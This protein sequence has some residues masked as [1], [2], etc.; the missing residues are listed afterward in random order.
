MSPRQPTAQY[1]N[2]RD[3]EA[4]HA[5]YRR[6]DHAHIEAMQ[7][8]MI[9]AIA[10]ETGEEMPPKVRLLLSAIQGAH[11]GGKVVNEE[12]ERNYLALADQLQFTGNEEARRSR[13]RA[14]V[15][16]FEEWQVKTYHLVVITK[17]GEIVGYSDNKDPIY[18]GTKFI[19]LVKPI[20]DQ[21]VMRARETE[22]W[23]GNKEKKIKA[24]PGKALSAQVAWAIKQL[25]R[26]SEYVEPLPADADAVIDTN[27]DAPEPTEEEMIAARLA[28]LSEYVKGRRDRMLKDEQRVN[29]RLC[30]GEM[31]SDAEIDGRLVVLD[32]HHANALKALKD[33]FASAR[34]YL[35]KQ[36]RVRLAHAMNFTHAGDD[37]EDSHAQPSNLLTD[38]DARHGT[39]SG[40][41]G[42]YILRKFSDVPEGEVEE[43]I[44][45]RGGKEKLTPPPDETRI[46]IEESELDMCEAALW[47]ASRGVPVVPLHEVYDGICTC[48]CTRKKCRDGNHGCGSECESKGKHPRTIDGLKSAT[49]DEATIRHWWVKHPT[50]NIGGVT[51]GALRLVAVDVDPKSGG[52]ANLCNLVEAHGAEWLNTFAQETGSRG[53]HFLFTYP[54]EIELRNTAG[55]LAVGIDTR[56]EGGYIVLAPSIHASGRRYAIA[57][58]GEIKPA[59]LW[60]IEELIRKP[61]EPPVVVVDFQERAEKRGGG[62]ITEGSRNDRLFRVGC[63]IWGAGAAL[64]K[65]DLYT[66]LLDE[67]SARVS[68]PL[69]PSEVVQIV[70]SIMRYPRGLPIQGGAA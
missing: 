61:T 35:S 62:I 18:S 21:A 48:S 2:Q 26:H 42:Y 39:G 63:G 24:H 57:N 53:S 31:L 65:S 56:A 5:M 69:N 32:V 9:S 28:K 55:K 34:Q 29:D 67:N 70:E 8:L 7:N 17:G 25:G 27:A 22:Q 50:A 68:P 10:S 66:Q 37:A 44:E 46:N 59:P 49:T 54:P 11:G 15:N 23:R 1:S 43:I 51:G 3:V 40:A 4:R 36:R 14:W 41:N 64:H 58:D 12:F 30:D 16:A 47:W 13:V 19:D 60:L 20:A 45:E 33:S 38:A 52:D 6:M